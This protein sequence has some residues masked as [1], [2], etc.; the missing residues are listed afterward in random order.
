MSIRKLSN[1]LVRKSAKKSPKKTNMVIRKSTKINKRSLTSKKKN[2]RVSA[3][4]KSKRTKSIKKN[5]KSPKKTHDDGVGKRKTHDEIYEK[6][7]EEKESLQQS[8]DHILQEK[9]KTDAELATIRLKLD[10]LLEQFKLSKQRQFWR[11]S[12]KDL[13]Q[14]DIFDEA[15]VTLPTEAEEDFSDEKKVITYESAY[16]IQIDQ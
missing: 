2:I 15:G 9:I 8:H 3:K 4:K 14:Y 13:I 12:E 1:S 16:S 11:S 7:T 6:M 10:H 5:R